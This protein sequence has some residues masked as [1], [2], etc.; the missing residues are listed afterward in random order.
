MAIGFLQP[1]KGLRQV[2]NL[3]LMFAV[4]LQGTMC[5]GF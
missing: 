2:A 4:F 5:F 1:F 3:L